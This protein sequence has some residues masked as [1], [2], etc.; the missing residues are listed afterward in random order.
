MFSW[1]SDEFGWI[2]KVKS[3][4]V[5]RG[6]KQRERIDFGETF[7]PTVSSSCVRLLSAIACELDP[8]VCHFDVEQAFILSK[9]DEDVFLRLPRGCGRLSGKIVRLIKSSYGLKQVSRSW[10]AHL[11]TCLKTLGFQQ[12]FADACVFRLVEKGRVAIKAGVHVDDIFAVGLE[13]RFD[14]FRDELNRMVTVKNLGEL[15]WYGG[16]HYTREREIDTLTISQKTFAD[17]LV[18][19]FCVTSTQSVPVRVGV[20]LEEFD[21]DEKVEN[22]PF[23][24]LVGS[25]M[26]LSISTRPDIANAVRAVARYCTARRAIHWKAALSI[27]RYINGTSE[28]GIIFQRGTLSGISLEV[29]ADADY[30]SKATDRRSVSGGLLICGGASVVCWFYRTQKCVALSTSEAEYVA[31]GD[32]VKV[33][34][35]LRQVW[36]FMLPSKVMPYFSVFEDNQGA[37]QLAQNPVTNSNSKH[38]DVRHHFLG[39]RVRQRDI[40]VVH[41]PSEFQHADILTKALAFDLFAFH[42]K[43]VMNLK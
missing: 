9:L 4:L 30:A 10:H 38:S 2:S 13:S 3:R 21:E 7:A 33:L 24:E 20:K 35:F 32:A 41:V 39:E 15:R 27:L 22:W 1:K 31:L 12:C 40:K 8:D 25:S 17:E 37:V 5:A 43:F 14:V 23:R 11:T 42:R 19:K 26:W 29:F 28:Y 18:K 34:W 16:C 36:R 6:F